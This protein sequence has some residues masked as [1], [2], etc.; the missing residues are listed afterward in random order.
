MAMG[1][2][3]GA[4]VAAT[5]YLQIAMSKSSARAKLPLEV[6]GAQAK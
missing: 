1:L 4:D 5:W 3:L 2:L 6:N